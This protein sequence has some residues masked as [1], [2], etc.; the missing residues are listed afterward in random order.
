[1]KKINILTILV[2]LVYGNLV[3]ASEQILT[4]SLQN[5]NEHFLFE[6][7][8]YLP[9]QNVY[10]LAHSSKCIYDKLSPR[11]PFFLKPYEKDSFEKD[12]EDFVKMLEAPHPSLDGKFLNAF[13][14]KLNCVSDG[15]IVWKEIFLS[16]FRRNLK[17]DEAEYWRL[18]TSLAFYDSLFYKSFLDND[19]IP[20]TPVDRILKVLTILD[21]CEES[22]DLIQRLFGVNNFEKPSDEENIFL[23]IFND[24]LALIDV[25]VKAVEVFTRRFGYE[26]YDHFVLYSLDDSDSMNEKELK[27][28]QQ[29]QEFFLKI[30][31][32]PNV[33]LSEKFNMVYYLE[34]AELYDKSWSCLL[35]CFEQNQD[36][37]LKIHGLRHVTRSVYGPLYHT[38]E[39][40]CDDNKIQNVCL[41][42][43][44]NKIDAKEWLDVLN[45]FSELPF[46]VLLDLEKIVEEV[47]LDKDSKDLA[48]AII[49]K[50]H[51]V[52][53]EKI[54]KEHQ[55]RLIAED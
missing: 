35:N 50:N 20:Q 31:D 19:F 18:A 10:P 6:I 13:G 34:S 21:C 25:R 17:L 36:T 32:D 45:V 29:A 27:F 3:F 33:S 38:Y 55:A 49:D 9:M 46:N 47:D 7:S 42:L 53:I 4:P 24:P 11:F 28:I 2:G 30:V 37:Q 41:N 48:Q 15:V 39:E 52:I 1:M 40:F 44:R 51:K 14:N 16:L 5:L 22:S 43:I 23:I 26:M 8:L 54:L 12:M